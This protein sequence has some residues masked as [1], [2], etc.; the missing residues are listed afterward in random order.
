LQPYLL[1]DQILSVLFLS[2][3]SLILIFMNKKINIFFPTCRRLE[4]IRKSKEPQVFTIDHNGDNDHDLSD[5]DDL[6]VRPNSA[7]A[8]YNRQQEEKRVRR[9]VRREEVSHSTAGGSNY[10][11]GAA[12]EAF[13]S[14]FSSP[15]DEDDR[16]ASLGMQASAAGSDIMSMPSLSEASS[17]LF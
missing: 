10:S 3:F 13:S 7:M 2:C 15:E 8:L 4:K 17:R 11:L 9:G 16:L 12:D 6:D 5:N 14:R 1:Q